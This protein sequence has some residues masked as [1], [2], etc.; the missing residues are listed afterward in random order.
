MSLRLGFD[1]DGVLADFRGAFRAT[2]A[3][4]VRGAVD[5][6][7][8]DQTDGE[9]PLSPNDVRRV[10][11]HIAK[12]PNWWMEIDAYEPAQIARLYGL[13]R[14]AGFSSAALVPS[15]ATLRGGVDW[16]HDGIGG[17]KALVAM[18]ITQTRD[19]MLAP[20]GVLRHPTMR[21]PPKKTISSIP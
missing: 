21:S 11:D 20:R 7:D 1:I 5:D 8:P 6:Y 18:T 4:L 9:S 12:A 15:A 19:R 2:A 10:W 3:K 13:T 17:V 14:A 16:A